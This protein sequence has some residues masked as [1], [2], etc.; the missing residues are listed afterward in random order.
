VVTTVDPARSADIDL[1]GLQR[2]FG[3]F[4]RACDARSDCPFAAHGGTLAALDAVIT[5]VEEGGL[6]GAYQ[7][8]DFEAPAGRPG[9]WPLGPARLGYALIVAVYDES[10]WPVLEEALAAVLD[11]DWGGQLRLLSDVYLSR[12][13]DPPDGTDGEQT[14]W[15]LRCADREEDLDVSSIAEG[16]ELE[17]TVLGDPY[18]GRPSWLSGWR[19]PNVWCLDGVWPDPAEPLGEA[20]VDPA[21]APPALVFGGTGDFAT[22][23]E[24]LEPLADAVG[25]GH[26]V[27]VRSNTHVNMARNECEQRLATAFVLDP[28]TPPARTRC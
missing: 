23:A 7:L 18:E 28:S 2:T 8:G 9:T 24:Y 20:V 26:V 11:D 21:S 3:R 10:S 4:A 13:R 25:G 19:L 6:D 15:A 16:F 22:P 27:R 12:F 14:F 17:A 5:R 1:G